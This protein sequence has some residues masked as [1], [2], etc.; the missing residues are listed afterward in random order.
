MKSLFKTIKEALHPNDV[1]NI[2]LPVLTENKSTRTDDIEA[3]FKKMNYL[4]D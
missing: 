3:I 2:K 1:L 4:N